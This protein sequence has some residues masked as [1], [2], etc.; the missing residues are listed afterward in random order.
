MNATQQSLYVFIP[1][2]RPNNAKV[3][4]EQPRQVIVKLLSTHPYSTNQA[5]SK[6]SWMAK[7]RAAIY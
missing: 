2:V 3:V 5:R 7:A 4:R 6:G 1:T